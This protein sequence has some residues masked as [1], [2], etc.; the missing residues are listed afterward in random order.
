MIMGAL[1]KW[2]IKK[3][4]SWNKNKLE[5]IFVTTLALVLMERLGISST[6]TEQT[7]D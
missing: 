7:R 1:K 2:S 4:K 3:I 6:K 5:R